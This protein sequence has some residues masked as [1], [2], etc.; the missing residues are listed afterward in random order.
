MSVYKRKRDGKKS[1]FYYFKFNYRGKVFRQCTETADKMVAL[2]REREAY[3]AAVEGRWS[4]IEQRGMRQGGSAPVSKILEV[5]RAQG[6]LGRMT[7]V[8]NISAL[9]NICRRAYP[10]VELEEL[11]VHQL[12]DRAVRAYKTAMMAAA[13]ADQLAQERAKVTANSTYRQARSIFADQMLR[14]FSDA[15][16]D[17]TGIIEPFRSVPLFLVST[18]QYRRPPVE[19]LDRVLRAAFHG[20]DGQPSLREADPNAYKA[21]LLALGLGLRRNS[22]SHARYAWIQEHKTA[23]I[24]QLMFRLQAPAGPEA[25]GQAKPQRILMLQVESDFR[26]KGRDECVIPMDDFVYQELMALQVALADPAAPHYILHGS[27]TE[28]TDYVWDRLSA[29]MT[30]L[31]WDRR[32]KAHELRKLFGAEVAT[33]FGI[34]TAQRLLGHKDPGLTSSR[35]ADLASVPDLKIFGAGA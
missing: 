28:R 8:K 5:Y 33:S 23:S 18:R 9:R 26:P 3:K 16:Y 6:S 35:Y 31:G 10:D 22:A 14:T 24:S 29:W 12:N 1:E 27:L 4:T 32:M 11:A 21:F 17:L 15:G 25:A 19:L 2:A 30:A 20:V 7:I 34:Y 13:G